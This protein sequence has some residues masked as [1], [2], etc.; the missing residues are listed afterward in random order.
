[1]S[2]K[3]VNFGEK[4][5]LKRNYCK[6]QKITEIDDIDVTKISV[7][8]EEPYITKNYFKYF[9][10]Y[11]DNDAI[12]PLCIKLPQMI[13]YARKFEGNTTVSFKINDSILLKK[14]NQIWKRIC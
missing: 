12:R 8:K 4:K 13:S 5:F 14:Y 10:G 2:T 9:I 1:M 3:N 11:N 6:N 7:S